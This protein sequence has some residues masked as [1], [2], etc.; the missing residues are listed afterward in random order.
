LSYDFRN[1]FVDGK[2]WSPDGGEVNLNFFGEKKI[3]Y[4]SGVEIE[5]GTGGNLDISVILNPTY[6][7]AISLIDESPWFVLGNTLGVRWGY[8]DG[9]LAHVSDWIYGFLQLPEVDFSEEISITLKASGAGWQVSMNESTKAW[10]TV[11]KPRALRSIFEEIAGKYGLSIAWKIEAELDPYF[12]L[13]TGYIQ[14]GLTDYQFIERYCRMCAVPNTGSSPVD[15]IIRGKELIL[16]S[17]PKKTM[18]A[19]EFHYYGKPDPANNIF[20][21]D[22]FAPKSFGA[23]FLPRRTCSAVLYGINSDPTKPVE[24]IDSVGNDAGESGGQE[25]NFSGNG[26]MQ[27]PGEDATPNPEGMKYQ[28]KQDELLE[29]GKHVPVIVTEDKLKENVEAEL[30]NIRQQGAG[31]YGIEVDFTAVAIPTLVTEQIVRLKGVSRFFS[32]DYRIKDMTITIDDSGA[33]MSCTAWAHGLDDDM[34]LY[35]LL[36]KTSEQGDTEPGDGGEEVESTSADK[37]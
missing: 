2:I 27:T 30:S 26:S 34:S 12:D 36:A 14:A 10:S 13:E 33:N 25:N 23:L 18:P 3:P 32:T 16:I 21:L 24:K 5:M 19:A 35:S 20:P 15:M 6:P 8:N 7:E 17:T 1:P 29:A 4:V 31:D 28:A 11:K 37:A 22:S 9:N